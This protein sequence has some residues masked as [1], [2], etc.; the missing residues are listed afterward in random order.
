M[1]AGAFAGL[2]VSVHPIGEASRVQQDIEEK[3]TAGPVVLVPGD[4][5]LAA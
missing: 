2:T 1:R 5:S 4:V 3:R